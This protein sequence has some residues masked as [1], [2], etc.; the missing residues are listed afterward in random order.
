M[1]TEPVVEFRRTERIHKRRVYDTRR[2]AN[3]KCL[4]NINILVGREDS[5][6]KP[7][8]GSGGDGKTSLR[9]VLQERGGPSIS[10]GM[11]VTRLGSPERPT[12]GIQARMSGGSWKARGIRGD[13]GL[14]LIPT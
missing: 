5:G 11:R 12:A 7:H 3:D 1:V 6:E 10:K 9:K 2:T 14:K 13:S 8:K 4:E